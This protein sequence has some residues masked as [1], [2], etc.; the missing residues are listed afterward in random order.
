M[1][2]DKN[3]KYQANTTWIHFFKDMADSGDCAKM[4]SS[5]VMIYLI[6]K[7][8]SNFNHGRSFPSVD[9]ISEKAGLSRS[10]IMRCL[11]TLEEYGYISKEKDPTQEGNHNIYTVR[12]KVRI[13]DS[14]GSPQ[15]IATWDYIPTG[16]KDAVGEVKNV[17]VTGK[18]T[19]GKIINIENLTVNI[20]QHE[21]TQI[22]NNNGT[23]DM[24][25]ETAKKNIR[26]MKQILKKKPH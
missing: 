3:D 16:I 22:I 12:D 2:D 26:E 23:T 14:E 4:G 7:T 20:F 5:A 15:A 8:Y 19:N 10:Q 24:D 17:L 21:S 1:S 11:K 6:I 18:M 13:N 9:L 25:K